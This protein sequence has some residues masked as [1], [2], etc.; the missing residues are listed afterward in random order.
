MIEDIDNVVED[1]DTVFE[2]I[3][4]VVDEPWRTRH[5]VINKCYCSFL[6]D[7]TNRQFPPE[8]LAY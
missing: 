3:D 8:S 1:I 4:K 7:G 6:F 2:N 5:K